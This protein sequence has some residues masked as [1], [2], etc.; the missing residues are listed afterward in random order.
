[1]AHM[2]WGMTWKD[3]IFNAGYET[4]GLRFKG[5]LLG[6]RLRPLL[7]QQG[8]VHATELCQKLAKSVQ[9]PNLCWHSVPRAILGIVIIIWDLKPSSLV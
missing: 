6:F 5:A 2:T 4:T 3:I 7:K 1:M 9:V 8:S